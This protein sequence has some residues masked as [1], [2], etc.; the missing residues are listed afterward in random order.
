GGIGTHAQVDAVGY[1]VALDEVAVEAVPH[2]CLAVALDRLAARDPL[3]DDA[4]D[5]PDSRRADRQ[6]HAT[7]EPTECCHDVRPFA[8][9]STSAPRASPGCRYETASR[10]IESTSAQLAHAHRNPSIHP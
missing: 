3:G 7:R 1:R 10:S 8:F 2:R 9:R 4:A 6:L 5:Q